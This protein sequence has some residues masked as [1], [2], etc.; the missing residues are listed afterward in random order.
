MKIVEFSIKRPVTI[1]MLMVALVM[2]GWISFNRLPFNLLPDISYPTLTIRT[3]YPSSAPTE[4]ENH[5]TKP[6][7]DAVSIISNVVRVSSVSRA[8]VSDVTVEFEWKTDM[9]YA[10]LDIREKLDLIEIPK[11]AEQPVIL[12]FNPSFDPI[13]RIGLYGDESIVKLRLMAEDEI[14]PS[15]EAISDNDLTGAAGTGSGIA[16]VKVSGG[17]E[18]EIHVEI[19]SAMLAKLGIPISRVVQRLAEENINLTGGTVTE[20]EVEYLV[21]TLTEFKRIDEINDITLI[22]NENQIVTLGDVATIRKGSKDRTVITRVNGKESIEIAIFKEAGANTVRVAALVKNKIKDL[23][24]KFSVIAKNLEIEIV[25][26]QSRFIEQSIKDVLYTALWG[27]ALAVITLF[28]FLRNIKSTVIVGLAIPLSVMAS[29]FFMYISNI[30]LNI[31]SLGGLALGIGMLVD[32]SIVALES[33]DRYKQK[34]HTLRESAMLGTSSVGIAITA[35]T[36]TTICVF[37]PMIFVKGIVGQLF[38]DQALTVTYSLLISLLVAVTLIPMLSSFSIHFKFPGSNLAGNVKLPDSTII[39]TWGF[40]HIQEIYSKVVEFALKNKLQVII[41]ALFCF[42]VAW[43]LFLCLGREFIPE[44]SQGEFYVSIKRSE[45]TPIQ[46]TLNSAGRMEKI[47]TAMSGVKSVYT[48]V[49]TTSRI[50]G[51]AME[52]RENTAEINVTLKDNISR[53][54]EEIMINRLRDEFQSMPDVEYKFFRPAL[55]SFITPVEIEIT[56]Y[57]LKKL[58][59]VSGQVMDKLKSISELSDIKSTT[60]K[61]NPEIRINFNREKIAQMGL[62][63]NTIAETIKSYVSGTVETEFRQQ[64]RNVDIRVRADKKDLKGI[65]D[66]KNLIINPENDIPVTL[67][68]I[69]SI[70][71]ENGPGEIHRVNHERVSIVSA[72]LSGLDLRGAVSKIEKKLSIITLPQ[73]FEINISGQSREMS[74]AFS[75]MKFAILLAIFLVYLVMASQF[76][77]LLSPLIIILTIPF[78]LVGSIIA[79]YITNKDLSV[80]VLIGV[81]MLAGIAVNNAIVLVDCINQM[82]REGMERSKAIIEAGKIRLRPI[83]MTTTTTILAMIPMSLGIGKGSELRTAMGITVI[84]GLL[85]STLLT[86]IIIP[87]VYDLAGKLKEITIFLKDRLKAE[88]INQ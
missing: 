14:K 56:G 3:K 60:V 26:D 63:I 54:E 82:E 31:M 11:D 17:V 74:T 53:D 36:L 58:K 59:S 66:F 35:S 44:L 9:D 16:A 76:E 84:G 23:R 22:S 49:G 81:V 68:S 34:G 24:K 48:I 12:K 45:G 6:I 55:F 78:A 67:A 46:A 52:E 28:L 20:G 61:G 69:S 1:V 72:N 87:V 43:G 29:F 18:E 86:L 75:S 73:N 19:S 50:G 70:D 33:I 42:G 80:V 30:T 15:L 8:G 41:I 21:R 27:G 2:F 71:I 62:D 47:I 37:V 88:G 57:N 51:S 83:L 64:E 5:I 79:L 7:E 77:S 38:T 4:V 85:T 40:P 10:S 32:N 13:L 25:Y 39:G 65:K